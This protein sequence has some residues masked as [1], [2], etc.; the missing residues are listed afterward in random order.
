MT[1]TKG[2]DPDLNLTVKQNPG[3]DPTK[4]EYNLINFLLYLNK[5]K[6]GYCQ[7]ESYVLSN[8]IRD[9][10]GLKRQTV[11]YSAKISLL[12]F[13]TNDFNDMFKYVKEKKN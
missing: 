1:D 11:D 5:V 13:E 7:C 2:S 10:T 8:F 4:T 12:L 9:L 6:M 3:P